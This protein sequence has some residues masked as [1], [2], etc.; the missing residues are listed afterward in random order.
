M[1][2]ALCYAGWLQLV[3]GIWVVADGR[4]ISISVYD[5]RS[6]ETIELTVRSEW[7]AELGLPPL[8][9]ITNTDL[10]GLA[11]GNMTDSRQAY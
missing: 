9:S 6:V 8:T 11:G 7:W 3:M 1:C 4:A 5:P 10:D 2:G